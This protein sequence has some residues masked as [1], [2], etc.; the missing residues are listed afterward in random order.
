VYGVHANVLEYM[1]QGATTYRIITDQVGSVRLVVNIATGAIVERI[2]WYE[3]GNLLA[4][5]A[6]GFQPF[7]FAGGSRDVIRAG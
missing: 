6:P 5:S 4:D 1:V 3:F 7:R 2:D